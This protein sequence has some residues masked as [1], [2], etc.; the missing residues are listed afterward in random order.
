MY[1]VLPPFE[2]LE[3]KTIQDIIDHTIGKTLDIFGI[4]HKLFQRWSGFRGAEE[5]MPY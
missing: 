5:L 4:E 3:P 1:R 2:Y